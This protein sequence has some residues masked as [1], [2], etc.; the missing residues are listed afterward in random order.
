MKYT[1]YGLKYI[2]AYYLYSIHLKGTRTLSPSY[3]SAAQGAARRP[4]RGLLPAGV[5]QRARGHRPPRALAD[6]RDLPV[7]DRALH[8]EPVAAV[9]RQYKR[10]LEY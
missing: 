2:N 9:L 6:L 7:L 4:Q 5:V 8:L 3:H 10:V 1:F